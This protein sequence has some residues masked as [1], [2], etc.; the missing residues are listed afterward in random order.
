MIAIQSSSLPSEVAIT[1]HS[2][3]TYIHIEPNVQKK[4]SLAL[5]RRKVVTDEVNEWLKA[6]IVRRVDDPAINGLPILVLA[7]GDGSWSMH[8][9]FKDLNK[10]CTKDL[11]PLPEIDWKIDKEGRE[12]KTE[13]QATKAGSS[14]VSQ[15]RPLVM[16][17]AEGEG[18]NPRRKQ[19]AVL[20]MCVLGPSIDDSASSAML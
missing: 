10:A 8:I 5:D 17:F 2:L 12:E 3:D 18:V 11:Y 4:R 20:N 15:K 19:E 1:E 9:D 6:G 13:F 16:Y 14:F 7:K